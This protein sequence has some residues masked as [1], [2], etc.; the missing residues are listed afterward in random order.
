MVSVDNLGSFGGDLTAMNPVCLSTKLID[1]AFPRGVVQILPR[2]QA[3]R[4]VGLPTSIHFFSGSLYVIS[5]MHF[6][7]RALRSAMVLG[8]NA[9]ISQELRNPYLLWWK[10]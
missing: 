7:D 2:I 3:A 1:G 8:L 9:S 5:Y 6:V 10:M 4:L